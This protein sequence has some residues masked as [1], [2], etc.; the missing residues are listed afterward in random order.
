MTSDQ[1]NLRSLVGYLVEL[2]RLQQGDSGKDISQLTGSRATPFGFVSNQTSSSSY[3]PR[4]ESNPRISQAL[5]DDLQDA[6]AD[7]KT[8]SEASDALEISAKTVKSFYMRCNHNYLT[9][10]Q[11][12]IFVSS[13]ES[14]AR[15]SEIARHVRVSPHEVK[16]FLRLLGMDLREYQPN[17]PYSVNVCGRYDGTGMRSGS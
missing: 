12:K 3:M 7:R 17:N 16:Y 15:L 1:D 10:E 11:Q 5:D 4:S 14:G 6:M 13:V 8:V 2:S 9:Q